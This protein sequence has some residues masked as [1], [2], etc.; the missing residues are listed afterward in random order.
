MVVKPVLLQTAMTFKYLTTR[1]F[2]ALTAGLLTASA[3]RAEGVSFR[4]DVMAVLAKAGCSAG[5][6]HGNKYGKGGFKISLRGQDPDLDYLAL[7]RDQFGRRVNAMDTQ[8]S[9]ILLKPTTQIAHEGGLRFKQGSEEYEILRRWIADG[10]KDDLATAPKLE[11]L[12]VTPVEQVLVEPVDQVQLRAQAY[13]SDG[14]RRNVTT[15]TVY[16]PV[17]TVAT[18]SH[19]GKARREMFGETAVLVRFL[20]Q[21][22]AARV[23]FVPAR[24]GFVWKEVPANNYID[25]HVLAK[26]H[27][28]RI[29]PSELCSDPVFLRRACLDLLGILPTAQEASAF[30]G[31]DV[32]AAVRRRTIAS[33]AEENSADLRRRLQRRARLI[34]QLLERPEFADFWAVKWADLL[35]NEEKALDRKGVQSFYHW[36]R[37]SIAENKPLDRFVREIITARGSSYLNPAANYWR[38]CRD[39]VTRA[40]A[41]A[42]VFL[43]TRLQ[44]A[45]CHNHPF[46]RW[47]QD[48]YYNWADL[49]ARVNYKILEN[50]RR[51]NLDTH[52]FVGEQ[53]V[54]M[55]RTGEVTNARTARPA[56]PRFL[57]GPA[58][59]LEDGQDRLEAL[60]VWLTSPTNERFARAQINRIWFHLMGRGL[61]DPMDD[62][63]PTNPP[64]HAALLD[65]LAGDFAAHGFDLRYAIRLIM[66]SRAY[67]LSSEPNE[68]NG[69]DEI[70]YSHVL[71]RRL[72]AEQ[73]VDAQ[74]QFLGVPAKFNGY[75]DGLRAGQLPG[76]AAVRPRDR[77]ASTAD[78]FLK[79]FGKPMRLLTCECERSSETTMNQAF[80]LISG[81]AMN[82]LLTDPDNRPAKLLASGKSDTEIVA[83]L[84]W[85]ALSRPPS[86]KESQKTVAHLERAKEK[87]Q[88]LEDLT[89]ALLNAK[90][91][92]LRY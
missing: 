47:S 84:Y 73:L 90:E 6:C 55:A 13:F 70:N 78:Q 38:A 71:P 2:V 88:A 40:E 18:V 56:Q 24:P 11:K 54:Y 4:N 50:K 89:W 60:A 81:P 14:S 42:Q 21:Q 30:L 77:K 59:D 66:N 75:P 58:R 76:V 12:E 67:Q 46:D 17:N 45:Q 68:T 61:V 43:G 85:T 62:F 31:A 10:M 53:I 49:F 29:N 64:S 79:L 26:L 23:A 20:N 22:V 7:T 3:G 5:N 44:C 37:Q 36:I 8:Q 32:A 28:L 87:R 19:D 15:L 52:E 34:E 72:T 63:R 1:G 65:A 69:D 25:E 83:E 82:E 9:L 57:G 80:Q 27:T 16:E 92:V 35:R 74:H 48:D 91:F 51:D 86:A 41:T 33:P 39:P